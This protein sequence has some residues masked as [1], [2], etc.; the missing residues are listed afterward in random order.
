M[1]QELIADGY[2]PME[3]ESMDGWGYDA[4]LI[5]IPPEEVDKKKYIVFRKKGVGDIHYGI[6]SIYDKQMYVLNKK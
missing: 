5:T 4:M 1:I 3:Y 6:K 2:T